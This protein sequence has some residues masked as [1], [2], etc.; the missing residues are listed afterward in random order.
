MGFAEAK[1][2]RCRVFQLL[3]EFREGIATASVPAIR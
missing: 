3:G 2:K 1:M